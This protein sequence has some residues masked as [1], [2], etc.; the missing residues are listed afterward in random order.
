[1]FFVCV[2]ISDLYL[3]QE[4][5]LL[6]PCFIFSKNL[7]LPL[8]DKVTTGTKILVLVITKRTPVLYYFVL[9]LGSLLSMINQVLFHSLSMKNQKDLQK[10]LKYLSGI[11]TSAFKVSTGGWFA[12]PSFPGPFGLF[13]TIFVL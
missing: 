5:V 4:I 3:L 10:L 7:I 11:V 12:C 1:M 8:I 2:V 13:S 6:N 9:S